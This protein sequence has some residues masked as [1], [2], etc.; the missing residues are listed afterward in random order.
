MRHPE[1]P[2]EERKRGPTAIYQPAQAKRAALLYN[3]RSIS[4][5]GRDDS[6]VVQQSSSDLDGQRK[7]QQQQSATAMCSRAAVTITTTAA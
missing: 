4:S 1:H 7:Q 6:C 2:L 5:L 3:L